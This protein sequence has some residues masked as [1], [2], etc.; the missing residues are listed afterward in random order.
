MA[1]LAASISEIPLK[2]Y[3]SELLD[4]NGGRKS[5]VR[6]PSARTDWLIAACHSN[7]ADMSIVDNS[8]DSIFTC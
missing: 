7:I 6:V 2:T 1:N 4:K 3:D 8:S 5:G